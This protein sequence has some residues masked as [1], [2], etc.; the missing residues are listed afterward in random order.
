MEGDVTAYSLCIVVETT[1]GSNSLGQSLVLAQQLADLRNLD[2][3]L[4]A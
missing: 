1:H 3:V 4:G 2:V